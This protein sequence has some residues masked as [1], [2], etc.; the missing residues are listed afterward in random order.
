MIDI[1]LVLCQMVPFFNVVLVT[2]IEVKREDGE[3]EGVRDAASDVV[4]F[5]DEGPSE[6]IDYSCSRKSS[7]FWHPDLK[8]VGQFLK[9][10]ITDG[11]AQQL[12]QKLSGWRDWAT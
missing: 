9:N 1:W 6:Q 7:G 2:A 4:L 3:K 12:A 5:I 11:V 8:T 10:A